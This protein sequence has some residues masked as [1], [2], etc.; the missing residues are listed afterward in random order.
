MLNCLVLSGLIVSENLRKSSP[1]V[2]ILFYK[3]SVSIFLVQF[4]FCLFFFISCLLATSY[5]EE[6]LD[7]I[8]TNITSSEAMQPIFP[9]ILL[10]AMYYRSIKQFSF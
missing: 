6:H 1:N 5:G 3:I 9:K 4:L 7:F 8:S 2:T 10:N